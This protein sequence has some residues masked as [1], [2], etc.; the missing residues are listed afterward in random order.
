MSGGHVIRMSRVQMTTNAKLLININLNACFSRLGY[1]ETLPTLVLHI[2]REEK[3][4]AEN[5]SIYHKS[6]TSNHYDKKILDHQS[7]KWLEAF[8]MPP[9]L[10]VATSWMHLYL[11]IIGIFIQCGYILM[12]MEGKLGF[13]D[14]D[15]GFWYA[16]RV[17]NGSGHNLNHL[18]PYQFSLVWKYSPP[19]ND[20]DSDNL[21]YLDEANQSSRD[22]IIIS[23]KPSMGKS[24]KSIAECILFGVPVLAT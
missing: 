23:V 19:V 11:L 21:A 1:Q 15:S 18:M 8:Q 3:V 22:L 17:D 4:T 24:N 12:Q 16:I 2:Y 5:S 7:Y 10:N 13:W 20:D 6:R 9:M 14:G